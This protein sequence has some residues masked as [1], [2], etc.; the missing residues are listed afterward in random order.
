MQT[1]LP[2]PDYAASAA[3]LDRQRLGKMRSEALQ[4][5]R[6]LAGQRKGWANHPATRMWRETPY[7]LY[8]YGLA[9]CDEWTHR[10]YVDHCA[11]QMR[12]ILNGPAFRDRNGYI[13]GNDPA[14][15]G[16]PAFHASHRSNLLRKG[17]EDLTYTQH[18]G[19]PGMPP[20]KA[21]WTPEHYGIVWARYGQ[22]AL[23]ETH[24]G[25]FGWTEPADLP[26]VWPV[27]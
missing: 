12:E 11:E 16:D 18:K 2:Y 13:N 9:V 14:W 8:C 24:Y 20:R 26:Y 10:G 23:E 5:L 4:M 15:L 6:T 17:L 1:F 7:A 19:E 27:D 22:P 3:C 25:Q 21:L